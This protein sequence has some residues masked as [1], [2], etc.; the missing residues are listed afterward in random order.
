MEILQIDLR[1]NRLGEVDRCRCDDAGKAVH[2][3]KVE[4]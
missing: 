3:C 2:L 4:S 1:R